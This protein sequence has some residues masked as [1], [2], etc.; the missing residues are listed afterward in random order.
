LLDINFLLDLAI[1][2]MSTK[3][4][5]LL[6]KKIQMPQVVGALIAGI[7]LGPTILNVVHETAFIDKMAELGVIGLMF[8]AG[9]ETDISEMKKCGKASLIIAFLGVL[10][11]LIGGFLVAIAFS[12]T[13]L[14]AM[15][16]IQLLKNIFIG[17]I[18]TATSVSI[19]VET[20]REMGRLRTKTGTAILGAAVI[21]DI[22]GIIIFTIILGFGDS[23]VGI[24]GVL[25]R[26]LLFFVFAIIVGIVF[27]FVFKKLS[28]VYIQKRRVPIYGLV[29]CLLLSFVSERFFGITD[30]TG[31]YLAGIIISNVGQSEYI[32]GKFEVLSYMLLS[33]IFFASIGIKTHITAISRA[34]LIFTVLLLLVAI[35]SKIIGCGL[36]AKLTG[37]T[38][39]DSLKI[40]VGMISRGEVALI[41]AGKGAEAGLMSKVLFVPIVIVVIIT[42]LLTPMLLKLVYKGDTDF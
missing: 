11:P 10:I 31:A 28:N 38:N 24:L 17:V 18:L 36:G 9:L 3:V 15:T 35:L 40:G 41:L 16:E 39:K 1:I 42:T 12:D 27:N 29:F 14:S 25:F 20:L 13:P 22:I 6:T 8:I 19:T 32:S 34:T 2:L 33:P 21:D 5:G 37:F 23:S 26:I 30:I 7:I 4:L